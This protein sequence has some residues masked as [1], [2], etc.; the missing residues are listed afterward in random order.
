MFK[1]RPVLEAEMVKIPGLFRRWELPQVLTNHLAFRIEDAGAHEDGTPL[2]A[3]YTAGDRDR[4]SDIGDVS[5]GNFLSESKRSCR[6]VPSQF[7]AL[8]SSPHAHA[9]LRRA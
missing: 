5:L 7:S 4:E 6:R 3:I 9:A 1:N 8:P 2:L